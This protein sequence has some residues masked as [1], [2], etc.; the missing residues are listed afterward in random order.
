MEHEAGAQKGDAVA[1]SPMDVGTGA[2]IDTKAVLDRLE[3]LGAIGRTDAGVT[4]LA[5]ST[6]DREA[7]RMLVGWMEDLGLAVR[8]DLRE[9]IVR[10]LNWHRRRVEVRCAA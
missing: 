10:T 2:G 4:R 9:A 6:E 8:I 1:G 5:F 7:R 3:A